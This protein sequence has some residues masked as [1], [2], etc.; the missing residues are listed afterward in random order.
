MAELET[1]VLRVTL[2]DAIEREY[3]VRNEEALRFIAWCSRTV[4]NGD[5]CYRIANAAGGPVDYLMLDKIVCVTL[6]KAA[7]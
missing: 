5:P 4:N 7:A 3:R 1:M 6:S 2:Q